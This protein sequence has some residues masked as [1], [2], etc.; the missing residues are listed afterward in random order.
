MKVKRYTEEIDGYTHLDDEDREHEG[1]LTITYHWGGVRYPRYKQALYVDSVIFKNDNIEEDLTDEAFRPF[2]AGH[3][4][5]ANTVQDFV[6][7]E[8]EAL[9][10][11]ADAA[12]EDQR[13]ARM[14]D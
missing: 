7:R 5:P 10:D 4:E 9:N 1:V 14:F 11:R 2:P 6:D 12:Y 3:F 13:D 8:I